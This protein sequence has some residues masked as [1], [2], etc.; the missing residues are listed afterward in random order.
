[1]ARTA[2]SK[3][4]GALVIWD[5]VRTIANIFYLI[6]G[7][8]AALIFG[9][10]LSAAPSPWWEE[11]QNQ[12]EPTYT[13]QLFLNYGTSS[14]PGIDLQCV[15]SDS[16]CKLYL[17]KHL[18]DAHQL[19]P[20]YSAAEAFTVI[21]IVLSCALS[22]LHFALAFVG[23]FLPRVVML[24]VDVFNVFA[25]LLLCVTM[26]MPWTNLISLHTDAVRNAVGVSYSQAMC[27]TYNHAGQITAAGPVCTFSALNYN[28]TV[29]VK[30]WYWEPTGGFILNCTAFW[31]TILVFLPSNVLWLLNSVGSAPRRRKV[32]RGRGMTSSRS[33]GQQYK[34]N[35]VNKEKP[36][37]EGDE[38]NSGEEDKIGE[39][40]DNDNGGNIN[41][42]TNDRGRDRV[43]SY[44][45]GAI[46]FAGNEAPYQP[47]SDHDD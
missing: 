14:G 27:S 31:I 34:L 32:R 30:N 4:L 36:E 17:D 41:F 25:A 11:I 1:V 12:N 21:S 7:I 19:W 8:T 40:S 23:R 2:Q 35:Q 44:D 39:A 10:M 5:R 45:G 6:S 47:D 43:D 9:A 24:G 28:T 13:T 15:Y 42:G 46:N 16:D 33:L 22:V 37:K 18:V 29:N 38:G 3:A 20:L 26:I